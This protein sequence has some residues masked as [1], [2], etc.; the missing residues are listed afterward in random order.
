[1]IKNYNY[2]KN[3]KD[4][5]KIKYESNKY[6]LANKYYADLLLRVL[7]YH[8]KDDDNVKNILF[9]LLDLNH[10]KIVLTTDIDKLK[11]T[12]NNNSK[13]KI[14]SKTNIKDDTNKKKNEL[15]K[16]EKELDNLVGTISYFDKE[17][18]KFEPK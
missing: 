4:K 18:K 11:S 9:Q 10:K 7:K 8:I 3:D 6:I 12:F 15:K 2:N 13:A 5:N 17:L 16:K 1:M 14:N